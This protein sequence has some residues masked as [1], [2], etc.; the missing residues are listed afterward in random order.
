MT[1]ESAPDHRRAA[2]LGRL[3]DNLSVANVGDAGYFDA[4]GI[5]LCQGEVFGRSDT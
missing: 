2:D 1:K 3:A 4:L 5:R